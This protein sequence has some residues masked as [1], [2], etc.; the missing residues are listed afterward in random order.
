MAKSNT[1]KLPKSIA[2]VKVPKFLRTPG[3]VEQSPTARLVE[4]FWPKP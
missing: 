3:T 1:L 4:L 2:G